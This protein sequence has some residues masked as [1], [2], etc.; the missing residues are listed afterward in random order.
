MNANIKT[1]FLTVALMVV[2]VFIYKG[3]STL[4]TKVFPWEPT[5]DTKPVIVFVND[6]KS[7]TPTPLVQL[8]PQGTL[9]I[10]IPELYKQF[11][12][13]EEAERKAAAQAKTTK[14]ADAPAA[15]ETK[16]N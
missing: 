16:K 10:N 3:A 12:V 11:K 4:W 9:G 6:G 14:P 8:N 13:M 1:A 15:T 7:T 2:G 5:A